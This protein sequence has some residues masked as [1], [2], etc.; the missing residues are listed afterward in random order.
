[1][2]AFRAVAP[3]LFLCAL[4]IPILGTSAAARPLD[5]PTAEGG[6]AGPGDAAS[7]RSADARPAYRAVSAPTGPEY[8]GLRLA[9]LLARPPRPAAV[10]ATR[11]Q[12]ARILAAAQ[13]DAP[14]V[15]QVSR[16]GVTDGASR[17]VTDF[18][19]VMLAIDPTDPDHLL[20]SSK[21]F[22]R[23][24]GYD[25]YTGVFESYDAGR[26]WSQLQPPGVEDYDLTSDPVNTFDHLGNGY[27]TLL[28][29][30]SAGSY[31]GLDML[32]KTEGGDWQAPV[33]VDDSTLTDKQWI[34]GD[35]FP[36][37]PNAGNLYMS[38]TAVGQPNRIVVA[39]STDG[40][41]SWQPFVELDEGAV[42]G[43]VPA[44]GPDGTVYVLW[45]RDIFG[46]TSGRLLLARSDDGG[47]TWSAPTLVANVRPIPFM[48]P[49]GLPDR[50]FRSPASLPALA[51][52]P[53]NGDLFAAWADYRSG[54]ADILLSRSRDGGATWSAPRRMNDDPPDNGIDQIHPQL[55]VA[56]NGRVSLMWMD[57]RLPCPDL[58]WIP[59]EHVGRENFCL[60]T[61]LL[62][63]YDG[64][65]SWMGNLRVGGQ[66]WDWS[67]NLPIVTR[68]TN[69][70]TGFIGDYQ[71]LAASDE[72]DYP[73]WAATSNLGQN[74]ENAQM[75]FVAI[76]AAGAYDPPAG[77]ATPTPATA[78]AE[79]T[80][81]ATRTATPTSSATPTE[82]PT[83]APAPAYLPRLDR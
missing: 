21:F 28:T 80:P 13:E 63:S 34:A 46:G 14:P 70:D 8:E 50:N 78:T 73:F 7:G 57:R 41:G 69:P 72:A 1:M 27:F 52:S 83:P 42:Q 59:A 48:L 23:P 40:N 16:R 32:R 18:S 11:A 9:P 3:A 38:W 49:N 22:W 10:A 24:E 31:S 12:A 68:S 75:A 43:S 37:S 74:P 36:D 56:P 77:S 64:G 4:L 66:T 45:G 35:A 29:R 79:A 62:R 33:L 20:G 19:E 55:A 51:V 2:P 6:A 26:T 71:G 53:A 81:T 60:D 82:A 15:V 76:V 47:V 5:G 30:R 44:V 61:F 17:P 39:R 54:D 58:D 65:D 67:L 25:F